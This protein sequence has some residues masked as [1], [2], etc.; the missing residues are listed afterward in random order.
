MGAFKFYVYTLF[1]L[2]LLLLILLMLPL[3]APVLRFVFSLTDSLLY[4]KPDPRVP[5]TAFALALGVSAY[6]LYKNYVSMRMHSEEYM[7]IKLRGGDSNKSL[8]S[9]LAAERNIWISTCGGA[10]W[11]ILF[12]YRSLLQRVAKAEGRSGDGLGEVGGKE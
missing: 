8:I 7:A 4:L 10:L 5:V 2:P 1:P 12:R 9:L 11:V 6:L 3:P